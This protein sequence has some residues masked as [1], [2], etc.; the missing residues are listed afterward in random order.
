MV[1]EQ[2]H[3]IETLRNPQTFARDAFRTL[4]H[5]ELQ[6]SRQDGN[7]ASCMQQLSATQKRSAPLECR[8]GQK[9]TPRRP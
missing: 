3:H 2:V 7:L 4:D 9:Q 6:A 8:L 1:L 5:V